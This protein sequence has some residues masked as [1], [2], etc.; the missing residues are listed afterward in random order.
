MVLP[1]LLPAA[2]LGYALGRYSPAVRAPPPRAVLAADAVLGSSLT[3]VDKSGD[4]VFFVLGGTGPELQLSV[5]QE[6]FADELEVITYEK[7]ERRVKVE[8][9]LEDE[10][11]GE[12]Y[13]VDGD[14]ILPEGPQEITMA[15]LGILAARAGVEWIGNQPVDLPAELE[16]KLIDDELKAS[17]PGVRP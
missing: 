10:D 12:V 5:N 4:E 17:R 8:G 3:I 16:A 9:T 2:T 14:F 11:D 6:L 13:E 7:A 1:L 15:T